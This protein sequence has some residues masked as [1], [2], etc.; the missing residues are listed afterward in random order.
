MSAYGS[1]TTAT[2]ENPECVA[3]R[4]VAAG[5]ANDVPIVYR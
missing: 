3:N 5:D 1:T 2:T 4:H